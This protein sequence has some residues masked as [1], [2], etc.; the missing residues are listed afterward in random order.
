[1]TDFTWGPKGAEWH[2]SQSSK[3]YDISGRAVASQKLKIA[4]SQG[5]EDTYFEIASKT[6][7][8]VIVDMQNFFLSPRCRDHPNG[9]KAV[10]PTIKTIEKCREVG[11]QVTNFVPFKN[12]YE[13]CR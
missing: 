2:Y 13:V 10:E 6:T 9:L 1:M 11:I 12:T 8:L 5:P 3:T 7:A 4:T